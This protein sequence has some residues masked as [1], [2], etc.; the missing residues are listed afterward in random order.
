M[1]RERSTEDFLGAVRRMMRA[2]ARRVAHGDEFELAEFRSIEQEYQ[3]C[4]GQAVAGQRVFG[5]KSWAAIGEGAGVRK[6]TAQERWGSVEFEL[7]DIEWFDQEQ[8][9]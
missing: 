6:Q 5:D 8:L 1:A 4:L 7:W 3:Y 2:A 9:P